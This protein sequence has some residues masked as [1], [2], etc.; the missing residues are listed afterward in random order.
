[1]NYEYSD[2]VEKDQEKLETCYWEKKKIRSQIYPKA[3]GR[4][5]GMC[6]TFS[7]FNSAGAIQGKE[8]KNNSSVHKYT[9]QGFKRTQ[10]A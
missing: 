1:M 2:P 3:K 6:E 4:I 8:I 5:K 10:I 9:R 7:Y